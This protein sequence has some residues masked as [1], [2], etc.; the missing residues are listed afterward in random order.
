MDNQ[1]RG[2]TP[3]DQSR[4]ASLVDSFS[5]PNNCTASKVA[6]KGRNE[7]FGAQWRLVNIVNIATVA[8]LSLTR[9]QEQFIQSKRKENWLNGRWCTLVTPIC[10]LACKLMQDTGGPRPENVSLSNV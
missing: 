6:A 3:T 1:L 4:A 9:A 10:Q 7:G 8:D 2:F 5:W